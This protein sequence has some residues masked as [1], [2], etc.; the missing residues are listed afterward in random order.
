M[1]QKNRVKRILLNEGEISRNT[2]IRELYITR[3]SDI[4]FRLKKEGWKFKEEFRKYEHGVD[5]VYYLVESPFKKVEYVVPELN[6]TIT[7]YE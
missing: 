1:S 6:K 2:C 4:I 3:L 7:S 5:Y